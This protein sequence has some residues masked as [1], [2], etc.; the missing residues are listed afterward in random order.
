VKLLLPGFDRYQHYGDR[1]PPW[2]KLP[3]SLFTD[4]VFRDLCVEARVAYIGLLLLATD[5]A[6]EAG[7]GVVKASGPKELAWALALRDELLEP[8]LAGLERVG[9]VVRA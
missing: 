1:R 6:S 3:R 5:N 7:A 8:A 9:L 2:V 4:F